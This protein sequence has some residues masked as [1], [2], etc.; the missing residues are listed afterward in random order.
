MSVDE[1]AQLLQQYQKILE[2][3]LNHMKKCGTF[4]EELIKEFE[5][6]E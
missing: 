5:F 4:E 2:I 6:D 1:N 3:C